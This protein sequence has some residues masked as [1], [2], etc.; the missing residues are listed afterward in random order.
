MIFYRTNK[1][2]KFNSYIF[3]SLCLMELLSVRV[4][5]G[6]SY[7]AGGESS[8]CSRDGPVP[9]SHRCRAET[10]TERK[11]GSGGNKVVAIFLRSDP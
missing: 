3:C 4:I 11:V 6:I 8:T 1:P 2:D 5:H 7:C 9:Q 10:L